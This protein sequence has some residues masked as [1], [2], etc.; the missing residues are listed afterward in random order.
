[1]YELATIYGGMAFI[2]GV[3]SIGRSMRSR[4]RRLFATVALVC[5]LTYW[6]FTDW[7]DSIDFS[8]G[9]MA[10]FVA[11]WWWQAIQS[12]I[13]GGFVAGSLMLIWRAGA[14]RCLREPGCRRKSILSEH[15]TKLRRLRASG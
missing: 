8:E 5:T 7:C 6:R 3:M 10:I 1:M 12:G 13:V 11:P 15:G 4:D 2:F 9:P 14:Q